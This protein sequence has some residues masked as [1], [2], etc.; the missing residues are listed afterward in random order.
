MRVTGYAALALGLYLAILSRSIVPRKVVLTPAMLPSYLAESAGTM[1]SIAVAGDTALDPVYRDWL[2]AERA[3]GRAVSWSGS[4]QP[5][6]IE[7]D[8]VVD[9]AG[10]ERILVAAPP[11]PVRLSDSLGVLD[12]T[13]AGGGG[14]G[15]ETGA[16]RGA[17]EVLV[18]GQRAVAIPRDSIAARRI[19]VFGRPSWETKFVMTALEERGWRVDARIPLTPDTAVVQGTPFRL[20]T[21]EVAAVVA[22][23]GAAE[24]EAAS[25]RRFVAQGG[26]L[27]LGAEAAKLPAFAS[28]RAGAPGTRITPVELEP[29]ADDPR[30]GLALLPVTRLDARAVVLEQSRGSVAL[31]GRRSGLG[32]VIQLGYEDTWRWRMAGAEGSVKAHRRWWTRLVGAVAYRATLPGVAPVSP[33]DAPLARTIARLGPADSTRYSAPAPPP[34]RSTL[35]GLLFALALASLLGE[36]ASRRWRGA[37]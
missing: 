8:P 23:D 3:S 21:A 29:P 25:I 4:I 18:S 1:D 33:H 12:S 14:A 22:L 34:N 10:G 2:A 20:D 17:V 16:V 32:R 30:R 13:S 37:I 9:P 24:R 26:G 27:V 5:V 15:F 19:A 28:F 36:W 6:A 31:A 11:G 35:T 7:V